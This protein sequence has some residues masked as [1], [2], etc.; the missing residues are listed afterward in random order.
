MPAGSGVHEAAVAVGGAADAAGN[1]RL[2]C[3]P[4]GLV[5]ATARL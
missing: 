1:G 2:H 5:A 4:A 3:A